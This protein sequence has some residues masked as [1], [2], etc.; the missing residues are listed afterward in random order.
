M[1]PD[2]NTRR[3][4]GVTPNAEKAQVF[5]PLQHGFHQMGTMAITGGLSGDNHDLLASFHS[6]LISHEIS[7][8]RAKRG[9]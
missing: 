7:S 9:L 4:H 2:L 5:I 6:S 1:D 3:S 8:R